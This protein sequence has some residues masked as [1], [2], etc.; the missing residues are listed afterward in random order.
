MSFK[1]SIII[2][3]TFSILGQLSVGQELTASKKLLEA[4]AENTFKI[5]GGRSRIEAPLI[6]QIEVNRESLV[7]RYQNRTNFAVFP[8]YTVCVFNRY[9]FLLG[10][11]ETGPQRI[12]GSFLL[13]PGDTGAEQVSLHLVDHSSILKYTNLKLPKDF[14]EAAWLSLS[15]RG[16]NHPLNVVVPKSSELIEF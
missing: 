14:F 15:F 5:T 4:H 2:A 10:T 3:T 1:K 9:G 7:V 16:A 12:G 6:T 11:G 8:A 13:D